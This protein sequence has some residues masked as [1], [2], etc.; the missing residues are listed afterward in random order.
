MFFKRKIRKIEEFGDKNTE[1][2][3]C[4]G[5]LWPGIT[6]SIGDVESAHREFENHVCGDY[7]NTRSFG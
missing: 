1:F 4:D 7:I 3:D 2:F 6:V 5:C